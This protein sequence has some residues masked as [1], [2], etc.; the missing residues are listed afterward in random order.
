[1]IHTTI[2]HAYIH[3]YCL[4]IYSVEAFRRFAPNDVALIE[5]ENQL[6][7]EK[8]K[9]ST[10]KKEVYTAI[11]PQFH[12]AISSLHTFIHPPM[13]SCAVRLP[14]LVRL[15]CSECAHPETFRYC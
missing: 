13:F 14:R 4:P 15:P 11:F 1:M 6:A 10:L 5:L 7:E 9:L 8:Q 3:T 12:S 2:I